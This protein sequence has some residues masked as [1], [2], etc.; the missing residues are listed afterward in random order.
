MLKVACAGF[1]VT[2]R[3]DDVFASNAASFRTGLPTLDVAA[4]DHGFS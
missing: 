2:G 4:L 1:G 3:F